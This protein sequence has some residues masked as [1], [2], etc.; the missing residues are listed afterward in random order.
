MTG[1]RV[2]PLAGPRAA[3]VCFGLTALVVA[4]GL[5]IQLVVTA[6]YTGGRFPTLGPRLVNLFCYFTIESNVL[7]AVSCLLLALRLDRPSTAFRVL[8]L[9][10]VVAITVTGIVFHLAL[11]S[12]QDLHGSAALADLVLHTAAPLLCVLGWLLLGPRGQ[13]T[14]RV[15][16]LALVFPLSWAALTL[17]KGPTTRF[18]P[19]PFVDVQALGYARVLANVALVGLLF[20]VLAELCR[21]LDRRLHRPPGRLQAG[22]R[23]ARR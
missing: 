10:A 4:A 8:R 20:V 12:L 13:I 19:Y 17:L 16:A 22:P 15:V 14:P 21:R 1:T 6:R 2:G 11:R 3:R 5:L 18:Y 9:T 23:P 7:V